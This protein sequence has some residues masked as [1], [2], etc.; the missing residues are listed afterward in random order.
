MSS[1]RWHGRISD[2]TSESKRLF[3]SRPSSPIEKRLEVDLEYR[4]LKVSE[5]KRMCALQTEILE[6]AASIIQ[7]LWRRYFYRQ[8][9]STMRRTSQLTVLHGND[10]VELRGGGALIYLPRKERMRRQH[11]AD[12]QMMQFESPASLY[13]RFFALLHEREQ[14]RDASDKRKMAQLKLRGSS[15]SSANARIELRRLS[16]G[17]DE[18]CRASGPGTSRPTSRQDDRLRRPSIGAAS[19]VGSS[20]DFKLTSGLRTTPPEDNTSVDTNDTPAAISDLAASSSSLPNPEAPASPGSPTSPDTS[21][22]SP[23]TSRA[24]PDTSRADMRSASRLQSISTINLSGDFGAASSSERDYAMA[25]ARPLPRLP[26]SPRDSAEDDMYA[27]HKVLA[28][29]PDMLGRR[30]L[31][32]TF[33]TDTGIK[34]ARRRPKSAEW[35]FGFHGEYY[36]RHPEKD[37]IRRLSG[38]FLMPLRHDVPATYQSF[39][40]FI[41]KPIAIRKN[42]FK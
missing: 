29:M 8:V 23:D 9:A 20:P 4:Y 28:P 40:A 41:T 37:R 31:V 10:E 18:L 12:L 36:E 21:R 26:R 39:E 3:K 5:Q 30:A 42:A 32:E 19:M 27:K 24:A 13:P 11:E 7:R 17:G 16:L 34:V 2:D 14:L 33:E 25:S 38:T 1:F 15:A 22:A 6:A 35:E